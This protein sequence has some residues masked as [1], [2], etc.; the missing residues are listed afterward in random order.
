MLSWEM[1]KILFVFILLSAHFSFANYA[2][3]EHAEILSYP[4]GCDYFIASGHHGYYLLKWNDGYEP[5]EGDI[6]LGDIDSHGLKDIY[7]PW[8]ERE[9][10]LYV[11]DYSMSESRSLEHY[12]EHC[13]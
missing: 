10:R 4:S 7:Y 8:K 9:G 2:L 5:S 11:E 13:D 3:A 12:K 6:I 1:Q